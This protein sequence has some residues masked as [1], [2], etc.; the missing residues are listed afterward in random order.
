MGA[1]TDPI[2]RVIDDWNRARP[3]LDP[4]PLGI[5]GR[6]LVLAQHLERS[7][8]SALQPHG[9]TFGQFDILATLRRHE[10]EGGMNPKQL[11]AS[12][13]L[14]SGGMTS[15]LDRLEQAGYLI[16]KPDP[17]D[18]RG[19]MVHLTARGR[20]VID[21][22]TETRLA[23]ARD[24]LPAFDDRDLRKLESLLRKWLLQLATDQPST[25]S[26]KAEMPTTSRR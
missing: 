21:S 4:H 16:R 25:T 9:L 7:V 6:I 15:R 1:K 5:I 18:R 24:S 10:S 19:V 20:E 8:E 22:A 11:I 13:A 23:E 3:D 14:S 26:S 2:D 12:V 17:D